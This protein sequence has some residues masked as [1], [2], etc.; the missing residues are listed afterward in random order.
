MRVEDSENN[1]VRF[2][3]WAIMLAE[4]VEHQGSKI[5]DQLWEK[6]DLIM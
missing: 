5:G 6:I 4:R 2:A 1:V 3:N